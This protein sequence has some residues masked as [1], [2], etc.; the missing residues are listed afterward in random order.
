MQLAD[1]KL[2]W[3]DYASSAEE[4]EDAE[5]DAQVESPH[6]SPSPTASAPKVD[7]TEAASNDR[8]NGNDVHDT[9]GVQLVEAVE[10][11]RLRDKDK[12]KDSREK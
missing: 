4:D 8:S 1:A 5:D 11:M 7:E 3:E 12:E 6:T 2:D 10:R 9:A